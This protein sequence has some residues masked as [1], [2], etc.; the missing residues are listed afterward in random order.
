MHS[1]HSKDELCILELSKK[2]CAFPS[3]QK[4]CAISVCINIIANCELHVNFSTRIR[5]IANFSS[6]MLEGLNPWLVERLQG[7][8]RL[9]SMS[10]LLGSSV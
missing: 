8:R 4:S 2:S 10:G 1:Q 7:C 3:F 5:K 9:M 6:E